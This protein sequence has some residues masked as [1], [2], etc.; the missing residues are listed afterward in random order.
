MPKPEI[1]YQ[2]TMKQVVARGL[3]LFLLVVSPIAIVAEFIARYSNGQ[4]DL[5]EFVTDVS[6]LF[7]D[8]INLIVKGAA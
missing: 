4:L 1:L 2:Q 5:G 3:G 6:E 8:C 7:D